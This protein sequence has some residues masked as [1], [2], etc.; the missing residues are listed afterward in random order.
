MADPDA[1]TFQQDLPG[2]L[3][4]V[5]DATPELKDASTIIAVGSGS[6][7]IARSILSKVSKIRIVVLSGGTYEMTSATYP[8]E[9]EDG[10]IVK[11]GQFGKTFGKFVV[12]VEDTGKVT[13]VKKDSELVNN[14]GGNDE[15]ALKEVTRL[16]NSYIKN[17]T[18]VSEFSHLS[19]D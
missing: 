10:Y 13:Y 12:E 5:I 15:D 14:K 2:A 19:P 3:Q 11:G 17:A 4:N 7:D 9:Y 16:Q 6:M 8:T 18:D 1:L